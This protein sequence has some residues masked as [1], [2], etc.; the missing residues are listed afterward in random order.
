M[1][2]VVEQNKPWSLLD[3]VLHVVLEGFGEVAVFVA[4]A[5]ALATGLFVPQNRY[6]GELFEQ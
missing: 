6:R 4:V 1:F 5:D 2:V 3:L